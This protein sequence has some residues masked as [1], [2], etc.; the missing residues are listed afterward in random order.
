MTDLI[1]TYAYAEG[2]VLAFFEDKV[3]AKGNSFA[4]VEKTA[5]EYLDSLGRERNRRN[6]ASVRH[7][8][9]HIVTPNGLKGEILGHGSV[10]G[11]E[12]T[13][14]FENG[15]IRRFAT[16]H[17]ADDQ[18]IEEKPTPESPVVALEEELN[19]DYPRDKESLIARIN[20]L[21]GL[22]HRASVMTRTA[23]Y[24][25]AS[26]IAQVEMM[27]NAEQREIKEALAHLEAIDA[28]TAIPEAMQ[29]HATEQAS[30]GR[31]AKD[32]WL[33]VVAQDM[34]AESEA[35]DFDQLLNEGPA[36]FVSDLNNV[37]DVGVVRE[38]AM[39]HIM[40]KT[41]GFQGDAV[42]DYRERFV[43]ATEIARRRELQYR[44]DEMSREATVKQAAEDNIPDEAL[45][46]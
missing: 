6:T 39:S 17:L 1:P 32:D 42:D 23:S 5:V 3:I 14:R 2:Q 24:T 35:Q 26:K 28:E 41:A 4:A 8:A 31:A 29:F 15:Q 19:A 21:A 16:T 36:E 45:F 33:E 27:A 12:I 11:D 44:Q 30:L 9:T 20:A 18:Y 7:R 25:D 43:A 38:L 34:I 13:V 37:D 22:R 46:I 40:S 10:W